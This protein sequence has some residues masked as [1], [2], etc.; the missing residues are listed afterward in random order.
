MGTKK[1]IFP[2]EVSNRVPKGI[3]AISLQDTLGIRFWVWLRKLCQNRASPLD[4]PTLNDKILLSHHEV[5]ERCPISHASLVP[6]YRRYEQVFSTKSYTGSQ[7]ANGGS[8]LG[9]F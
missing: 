7:C 1:L 3:R 6:K 8:S 4:Y 9:V 5:L 2:Y